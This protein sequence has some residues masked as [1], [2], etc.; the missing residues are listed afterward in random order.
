MELGG[1]KDFTKFKEYYSAQPR[2]T[3]VSLFIII[4]LNKN[5]IFLKE[6]TFRLTW[7]RK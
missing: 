7:K 5:E 4:F 2:K 1:L 6:S 3:D